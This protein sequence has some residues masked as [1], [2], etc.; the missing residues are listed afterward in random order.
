[1]KFVTIFLVF[2]SLNVFAQ[3]NRQQDPF[4]NE[5]FPP[6]KIMSQ[7]AE[8]GIS[9]EQRKKIMDLVKQQQPKIMET[10]WSMD[11]DK[12]KLD[13][14]I[15]VHPI[16]EE[17]FTAALEKLSKSEAILKKNH[18][19]FLIKIRNVLTNDQIQKLKKQ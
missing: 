4:A 16:D 17:K 11:A 10:K 6:N 8:L 13:K 3:K 15:K 7:T 14:L 12:K 9:E 5:L 1:M 2:L 19:L 18:L